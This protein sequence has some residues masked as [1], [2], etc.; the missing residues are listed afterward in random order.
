MKSPQGNIA[1]AWTPPGDIDT[2]R[3]AN[4]VGGLEAEGPALISPEQDIVSKAAATTN[5]AS[6]CTTRP[7]HTLHR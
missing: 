1:D 7:V 3:E 2:P 4:A 6:R 5:G